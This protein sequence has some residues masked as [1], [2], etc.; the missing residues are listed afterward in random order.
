MLSL[1]SLSL[2]VFIFSVKQSSKS[3]RDAIECGA[4]ELYLILQH[5]L[6]YADL[7]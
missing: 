4:T 3:T 2:Y 6:I 7:S 5:I 1:K